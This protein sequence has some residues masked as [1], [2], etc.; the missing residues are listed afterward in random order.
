[1]AEEEGER[2][3]TVFIPKV[4]TLL[5]PAVPQIR[6]QRRL[7]QRQ[8]SDTKQITGEVYTVMQRMITGL[9]MRHHQQQQQQQGGTG[10]LERSTNCAAHWWYDSGL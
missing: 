4:T 8:S 6:T 5:L 7:L 9:R 3:Y 1:M 10:F 2:Q